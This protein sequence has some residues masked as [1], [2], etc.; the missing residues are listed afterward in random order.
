MLL[1]STLLAELW[2]LGFTFMLGAMIGLSLTWLQGRRPWI[3]S[4]LPPDRWDDPS[5]DEDRLGWW[6]LDEPPSAGSAKLG[7]CWTALGLGPGVGADG[8]VYRWQ[9]ECNGVLEFLLTFET[10]DRPYH[11]IWHVIE[12]A[13]L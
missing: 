6:C 12:G 8:F 2:L 5:W 1:L 4:E 11:T 3:G 13:R 9:P 7:V 10:V